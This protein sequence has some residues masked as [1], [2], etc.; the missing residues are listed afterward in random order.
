M[1][2]TCTAEGSQDDRVGQMAIAGG[3]TKTRREQRATDTTCGT[4]GDWSNQADLPA[5]GGG[6]R[7][8][9][10]GVERRVEEARQR[11]RVAEME[12]RSGADGVGEGGRGGRGM[13]PG[14]RGAG[15]PERRVGDEA[16]EMPATL[17]LWEVRGRRW[18]WTQDRWGLGGP[19]NERGGGGGEAGQE[20]A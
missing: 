3:K 13:V 12:G 15:A 19:G 10:Q 9:R 17:G 4:G 18:Q 16:R 5:A 6:E 7:E 1:D 20:R 14:G 11:G 2:A 8:A